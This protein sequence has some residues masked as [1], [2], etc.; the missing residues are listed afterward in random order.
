MESFLPFFLVLFAGVVFSVLSQRLHIPWV[1]ALI[2]GGIALGPEGMALLEVDS[3]IRFVSEIG[4]VFLMFMAGLE[5]KFST[6]KHLS[7]GTITIAILHGIVPFAAGYGVAWYFEYDTVVALLFGVVFA[8][9]SVAVVF[10]ALDAVGVLD[11]R[12]GKA[13]LTSSIIADVAALLILSYV[14]QTE[15]SATTFSL[16]IFYL[17]LISALVVLRFALPWIDTFFA[18]WHGRRDVFQQELRTA[19]LLLIGTVLLF[20]FLGL[21]PVISGFFAGSVLADVVSH[22]IF[23]GKIRALSYGFFIPVFF[24]V[25]GSDIPLSEFLASGEAIRLALLMVAIALSAKVLSGWLG[26][27]LGGFSGRESWLVGWSTVPQLATTLAVVYMLHT[28]GL[29]THEETAPLI[30]VGIVLTLLGP[31]M[32]AIIGR[33]V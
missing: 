32:I 27:L 29:M 13:I 28:L 8:S 6:F 22:K 9:T 25:V 30:I 31:L 14:L 21:H 15:G 4:L 23:L 1:I 18:R 12:V 26:G 5:V 20:E 3:T 17:L 7:R 24:I 33:K 2:V 16:P 11:K 10:P 19:L